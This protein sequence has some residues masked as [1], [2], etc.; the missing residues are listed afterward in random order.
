MVSVSYSNAI[1]SGRTVEDQEHS[2]RLKEF[3]ESVTLKAGPSPLFQEFSDVCGCRGIFCSETLPAYQ[4]IIQ[5]PRSLVFDFDSAVIGC[6][7]IQSV[8]EAWVGNNGSEII[9]QFLH[10]H[11]R[12]GREFLLFVA[13]IHA[14][15]NP[16]SKWHCYAAGSLPD[17]VPCVTQWSPELKALFSDTNLGASLKPG[18]EEAEGEISIMMGY[19]KELVRLDPAVFRRE[20][21]MWARGMYLSRRFPGNLG[22]RGQET[23]GDVSYAGKMGCLLPGID[24]LNHKQDLL[25]NDKQM[26]K[27]YA[28]NEYVMFSCAEELAKGSEV[29]NSYGDQSNE[30]LLA[31]YGFCYENNP[32]DRLTLKL[33]VGEESTV[34]H[35][36]RTNGHV[37]GAIGGIPESLWRV[38]CPPGSGEAEQSEE[39][40]V[41]IHRDIFVGLDELEMVY[42][43]L[44]GKWNAMN[45]SQDALSKAKASLR[46]GPFDIRLAYIEWY[47]EGI[48][49][50]LQENIEVLADLINQLMS[51]MESLGEGIE[52]EEKEGEE[53]ECQNNF[54]RSRN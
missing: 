19:V 40:R 28:E 5:L 53:E 4:P 23:E 8:L 41:N 15:V 32:H 17:E 11:P 26:I 2:K 30:T 20:S 27:V 34:H 10:T 46:S 45:N 44:G 42:S 31:A 3:L 21:L 22:I 14:R 7:F 33:K 38:L 49:R 50:V 24:L 54:K 12:F 1:S 48:L 51:V 43:V 18:E 35:I 36:S 25:N 6:E 29:F 52:E 37:E 9:D 47:R 39:P 13:L 16:H